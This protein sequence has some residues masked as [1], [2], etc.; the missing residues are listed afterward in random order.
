MYWTRPVLPVSVGPITPVHRQVH[1]TPVRGQT[2]G[3]MHYGRVTWYYSMLAI[4]DAGA[5]Q[6]ET[7]P[8]GVKIGWSLLQLVRLDLA[9]LLRAAIPL[10][11]EVFPL[12]KA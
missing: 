6:V 4:S 11:L 12:P 2:K 9:V 7:I 8:H 1:P 10:T 5:I 3:A